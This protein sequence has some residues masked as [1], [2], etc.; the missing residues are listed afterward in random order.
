MSNFQPFEFVDRGSETQFKMG[1][2]LNYS[3]WRFYWVKSVTLRSAVT[4]ILL[5]LNGACGMRSF[6]FVNFESLIYMKLCGHGLV[7]LN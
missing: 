2:N 4:Y 5:I 3:I 6:N 7:I 1:E